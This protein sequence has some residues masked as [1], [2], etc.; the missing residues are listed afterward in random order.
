MQPQAEPRPA[1]PIRH[2]AL[3]IALAVAVPLALFA[4]W[5]AWTDGITL[6]TI[7][8]LYGGLYA[9]SSAVLLGLPAIW[10]L[11]GRGSPAPTVPII[12]GAVVASAPWAVYALLNQSNAKFL[13]VTGALGAVGGLI[14]W[15]VALRSKPPVARR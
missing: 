2:P 9:V 3:A 4:S 6:A 14:F 12:S 7:L 1:P 13:M 5:V 11:K 15:A 10:M 8:M